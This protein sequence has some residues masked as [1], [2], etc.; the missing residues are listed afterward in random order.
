M[1]LD[2]NTTTETL[3]FLVDAES[4]IS[5]SKL[6]LVSMVCAVSATPIRSSISPFS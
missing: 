3:S 4:P 5:L 6:S 1:S 2:D